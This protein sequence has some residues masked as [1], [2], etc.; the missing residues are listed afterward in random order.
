MQA[1]YRL[2][3]V[4]FDL[5]LLRLPKGST[6]DAAME[7]IAEL[8]SGVRVSSRKPDRHEIVK[9]LLGMDSR[10]E[11]FQKD[12]AEIAK[13][14]GISA[15]EARDRDDSVELNGE[16]DGKPLTQFIIY[17]DRIVVHWYSGTN[18][19]E[20]IRLLEA[21]CQETGYTVVDPQSGTLMDLS[22]E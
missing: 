15:Q 18:D 3:T 7:F 13:F 16:A 1:L 10:Y 2:L 19:P 9:L 4:S 21:L 12:Y 22:E 14:E 8:E 5:Y 20:M 11:L 17:D 6:A